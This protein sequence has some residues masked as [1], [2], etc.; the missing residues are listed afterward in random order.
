MVNEAAKKYPNFR[1][2]ATTHRTVKTATVNDWSASA[3]QMEKSTRQKIIMV[4][5]SWTELVVVIRLHRDL[6]MVL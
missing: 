4:L 2:V 6:Y 1:A 3:G 5:K